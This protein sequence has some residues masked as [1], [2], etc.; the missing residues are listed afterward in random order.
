M[1]RNVVLSIL[2]PAD[3]NVI[4][5]SERG[6]HP[7]IER[8]KTIR[9]LHLNSVCVLLKTRKH[10]S[11]HA[12]VHI[13]NLHV[14]LVEPI[15]T[16]NSKE[17]EAKSRTRHLVFTRKHKL[18]ESTENCN[19]VWSLRLPLPN[20]LIVRMAGDTQ[21]HYRHTLEREQSFPYSRIGIT[22]RTFD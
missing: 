12:I 3:P 5:T 7:L 11:V 18:P 19:P 22:F 20:G 9:K 16:L 14:A 4:V 2:K 8:M 21:S 15:V 17:A 10:V 6:T 13:G 1:L